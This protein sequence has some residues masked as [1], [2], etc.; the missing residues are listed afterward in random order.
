MTPPAPA[1]SIAYSLATTGWILFIFSTCMQ[2]PWEN[3]FE[4]GVMTFHPIREVSDQKH[5]FQKGVLVRMITSKALH[6]F[7]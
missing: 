6:L 5:V 1:F 4:Y 3:F 7:T 2:W